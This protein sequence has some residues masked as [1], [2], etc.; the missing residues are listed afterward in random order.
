MTHPFKK[1]VMGKIIVQYMPSISWEAKALIAKDVSYS[2]ISKDEDSCQYEIDQC[3]EV[4][5][6][7]ERFTDDV[8]IIHELIFEGVHFLEF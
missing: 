7:Y 6:S 5:K 8:S 3:L 2:M 4:L 1:L